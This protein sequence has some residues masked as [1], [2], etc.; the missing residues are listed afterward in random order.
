MLSVI[1]RTIVCIQCGYKII[2]ADVRAGREC[3]SCKCP[4]YLDGGDGPDCPINRLDT[5]KRYAEGGTLAQA[6]VQLQTQQAKAERLY[7]ASIIGAFAASL[8]F[9]IALLWVIAHFLP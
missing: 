5:G 3:P 8:A 4:M 1:S 2:G 6:R 9:A 7:R